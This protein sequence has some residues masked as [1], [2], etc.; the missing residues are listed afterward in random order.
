MPSMSAMIS[1]IRLALSLIAFMVST[2]RAIVSPPSTATLDAARASVLA[3]CALSAFLRT[4]PESSSI[5]ALVCSSALACSS[6]RA[7]RS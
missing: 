2:I 7:L 1:V 3:C 5:D 6:V 4:V